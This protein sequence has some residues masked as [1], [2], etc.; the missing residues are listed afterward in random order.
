MAK[1]EM[2]VHGWLRQRERTDGI[3]WL[4]CY[5]R[6]RLEDGKM[7]ENAVRLGLVRDI[8]K[9]DADAWRV[10]G[11]FG[12]VE[13]HIN[14]PLSRKPEFGEL[15]AAYVKDGLPFRKKDGRR[16]TRGTIETYEYHIKPHPPSLERCRC[17]GDET[18]CNPQLA[19]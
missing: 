6:P 9:S 16:K 4:W 3:T 1:K 13:K 5:Q 2:K 7:V 19:I 11:R 15:C 18:A 10:V 17:G 14:N 8:G 12:L